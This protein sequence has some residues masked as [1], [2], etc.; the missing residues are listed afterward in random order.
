MKTLN[1]MAVAVFATLAFASCK[2][3]SD[4]A[5][6]TGNF[7]FKGTKY[8]AQYATF[9][10]SGDQMLVEFT[11]IQPFSA[12][13]PSKGN[14]LDFTFVVKDTTAVPTG[15][16]TL[17]NE[18][19]PNF[20]QTKNY[21]AAGYIIGENFTT[22]NYDYSGSVDAGTITITKN[23]NSYS[24]TYSVYSGSDSLK[25]SYNGTISKLY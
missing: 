22:F 6:S 5:S 17:N 11:S 4:S 24:A 19:D 10:P 21:V 7:T 8:D 9:V 12:N 16:F 23:G 13:Y 20:D 1:M 15:T 25:G 14:Y 2:K 3:D 18:Y